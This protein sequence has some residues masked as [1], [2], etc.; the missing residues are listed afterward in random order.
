MNE[1]YHHGVKG[2]KW[3]VRKKRPDRL[4]SR[5]GDSATTRKVKE[6]YNNLSDQEFMRKYSTSKKTYAKRVA[7]YGD[8]YMNSPLAKAGKKL[9]SKSKTNGKKTVA[10]GAATAAKVLRKIGAAYLTDQLFFGGAGT[11][12]A[13]TGV[14][15]TG[16]AVV[17][18]Y[19]KA[20]GATDIRWYDNG[21]LD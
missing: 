6:D 9:A 17:T 18:A 8:P 14:K 16:R 10:K 4:E 13:K 20:R 19:M 11:K 5:K 21:I 2:M 1:L 7:R 15:Y 3:G 12:A